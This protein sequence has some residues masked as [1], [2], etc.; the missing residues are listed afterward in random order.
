MKLRLIFCVLLLTSFKSFSQNYH[1]TPLEIIDIKKGINDIAY[2]RTVLLEKGFTF[3]KKQDEDE[4]WNIKVDE[5][6]E[7]DKKYNNQLAIQ[8]S[9][10]K[11]LNKKL[12]FFQ[13]RRDLLP[14]YNE[15]FLTFVKA[16]FPMKKALPTKSIIEYNN[17]ETVKDGYK[18]VYFNSNS[19]IEVEVEE[20]GLWA[21]YKFWLNTN[22]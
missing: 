1:K 7:L 17:K 14:T 12:I 6:S 20:E 13:I 9:N 18:L 22:K 2:F 10:W 11:Y 4:F 5:G 15:V 3:E 19:K 8:I 16:S 21:T